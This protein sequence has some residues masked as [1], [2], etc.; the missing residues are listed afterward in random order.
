LA[1]TIQSIESPS[2]LADLIISFMD[3]KAN[4]KQE[5]LETLNLQ[6]RLDKVL[7]VLANRLEVL[8]IT[9][10]ISEQTQTALGERQRE[11]VLR[12]QLRQLQKELGEDEGSGVEMDELEKQ[13]EQANMPAEVAEH[14]RKEL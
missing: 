4:E 11:A 9:R 2:R 1:R 3:V 13:V 6:E 14:A 8:K 10:D 12:E 5:M 7:K